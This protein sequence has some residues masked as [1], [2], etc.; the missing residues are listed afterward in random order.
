MTGGHKPGDRVALACRHC[1][2]SFEYVL[3]KHAPAYCEPCKKIRQTA[4]TI[5]SKRTNPKHNFKL[6][7]GEVSQ[8]VV[9]TKGKESTVAMPFPEIVRRLAVWEAAEE[10]IRTGKQSVP[11]EPITRQGARAIF[12]QAIIKIRRA[13]RPEYEALAMSRK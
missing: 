3:K 6:S 5:L 2:E 10:M 4:S 9:N 13:C 11:L 1:G 12:R 8:R 7:K